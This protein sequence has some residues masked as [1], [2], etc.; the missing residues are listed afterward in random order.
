VRVNSKTLPVALGSLGPLGLAVP[1]PVD[2]YAINRLARLQ[3]A[4]KEEYIPAP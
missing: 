1:P 3:R 4:R 2:E